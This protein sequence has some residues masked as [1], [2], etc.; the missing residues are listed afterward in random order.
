MPRL[1]AHIPDLKA[2]CSPSATAA[3]C[4][5]WR[6]PEPRCTSE[7]EP[8]RVVVQ[9]EGLQASG[10]DD[11]RQ[12]R[13]VDIKA[14]PD[15]ALHHRLVRQTDESLSQHEGQIDTSNGRVYRL[16]AKGRNPAAVDQQARLPSSSLLEHPDKW[17]RQ[18]ALRLLEIAKNA[19]IRPRE[20]IASKSSQ[21]AWSPVGLEPVQ[22]IQRESA[23]KLPDHA[24]PHVQLWT[25][26]LLGMPASSRRRRRCGWPTGGQQT[27]RGIRS[28]LAS[29]T[30]GCGDSGLAIVGDLLA[31]DDAD[32]IH[33]AAAVVSHRITP[34]REAVLTLF[35]DSSLWTRRSSPRTSCRSSCSIRGDRHR[36]DLPF[37]RVGSRFA[38]QRDY[39][40]DAGFEEA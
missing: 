29:T 12:F 28:Q 35:S 17:H 10:D 26:Y 30:R 22:R 27:T 16:R 19:V 37:A 20:M 4:S 2:M 8:G 40:A 24:G 23:A 6:R 1:H 3:S 31:H 11:R 7:I 21:T 18:T 25:A 33:A 13:P 32:D 15:G 39:A 34:D 9:D 36:K 38:R 5:A 14:G